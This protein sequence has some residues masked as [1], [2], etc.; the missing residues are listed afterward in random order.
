[1][2]AVGIDR[3]NKRGRVDGRV[4]FGKNEPGAKCM[5]VIEL[6]ARIEFDTVGKNGAVNPRGDAVE[7]EIANIVR[8][9]KDRAVPIEDRRLEIEIARFLLVGQNLVG[10]IFRLVL[11]ELGGIECRPAINPKRRCL[12]R[13][14]RNLEIAVIAAN[15]QRH[16]AGFVDYV[17]EIAEKLV[18]IGVVMNRATAA[19]RIFNADAI[20]QIIFR[21]V[22]AELP[23]HPAA[24]EALH[25]GIETAD[26]DR[27]F[28]TRE[29]RPVFRVNVDHAGVAKSELRRQSPGDERNVIGETRL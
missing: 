21:D 7:D 17:R 26:A 12:T 11:V 20:V 29:D 3:E 27:R 13:I 18:L 15:K 6:V 4:L 28:V 10:R 19:R 9:K 22:I 23:D 25:D 8:A 5:L 16:S 1:M 14:I 24:L 2:I